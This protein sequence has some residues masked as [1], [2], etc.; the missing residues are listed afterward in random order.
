MKPDLFQEVSLPV[1]GQYK[2]ARIRVAP[3]PL[4]IAD[5]DRFF[6]IP[7]RVLIIVGGNLEVVW[8]GARFTDVHG[9]VVVVEEVALVGGEVGLLADDD[10]FNRVARFF[11]V[12]NNLWSSLKWRGLI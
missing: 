8:I 12:D 4:I 3:V 10:V 7:K 9:E 6:G 5:Q 1:P 2:L 11:V